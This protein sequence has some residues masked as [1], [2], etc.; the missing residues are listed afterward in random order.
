MS[1]DFVNYANQLYGETCFMSGISAVCTLPKNTIF[2]ESTLFVLEDFGCPFRQ[3]VF[4]SARGEQG[5]NSQT[6]ECFFNF[7]GVPPA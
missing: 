6:R 7:H 2:L 3:R 1:V 4:S 5:T